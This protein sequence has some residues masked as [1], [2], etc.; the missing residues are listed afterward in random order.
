MKKLFIYGIMALMALT[1]CNDFL[2]KAPLD[3]FTN[4]PAYWSNASNLDNQCNTFFNNYLGYG[5]GDTPGWFYFKTLSDDQVDYKSTVWTYTALVATSTNW[6]EPFEEI[7]RANYIL[8]GL[9][10]SS[11][12]EA[13]KANYEGIARMNRAWKYYQLVRMYGDVQWINTPMDPSE[14]DIV[15]G[16]RTDRDIVMDSILNDLN[17][18][19]RT[20]TGTNKQRFTADMALAM[21]AD[22]TLYEGTYCKYRT[23]ADNAGKDAD[24]PRAEK[25]L[26]E[27]V[28][29]CEA[30]MAKNYTLNPS[31][32]GN[33]NSVSLS[34]NPEMIFYKPYSQNSLMHSVVDYTVN[35]SGTS[36]MTKDAFDCYLFLDGKPKATTSLDTNDAVA[37]DA[38]GEYNL[39]SLLNV[40]DKRLSETIDS[41]LCFKGNPY[42]RAGVASFTSATGYGVAKYDNP[43]DMTKDERNN[44]NKQYTDCPIFWLSV[45][46][47]NFAEAKAELGTL[48]NAD[49]DNSINKLLDRAGLPDMTVNPEAD[50]ANNMGVSNL[51]W[52]IRRCR[53]CELMFDNWT[54]YWDLIRWHKLD[55][56]DSGKH[57]NIYLGANL[58]HV[59]SPEVD[60]N[61]DGYMI[62]SNTL[63]QPRIY[64]SKYYFYPIPTTQLTLNPN[65]KQNPG[66]DKSK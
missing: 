57:P 54:R 1:S 21:K 63:N 15:Y 14:K 31:Y 36:G 32:K 66:W 64:D 48:T 62:G 42:S 47:L 59:P 55:L 24:L 35:T 50:P 60:V 2:D 38:N 51:L 43:Q 53:R 25:Y 23:A 65:M 34:D 56:L 44:I 30:L 16:A 6:S 13:V 49:L 33:Y 18:A 28:S 4:T 37:Q 12:D 3:A 52:E 5:N 19:T 26:K 61:S 7:R 10:V 22:I 8:A 58:K 46:Y 45:V 29:A 9:K 17:Y 20:I 41:V 11:L 40:R 27:C 39:N